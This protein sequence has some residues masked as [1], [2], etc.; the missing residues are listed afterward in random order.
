MSMRF[1]KGLQTLLK[2]L[3]SCGLLYLLYR[4]TPVDSIRELLGSL[5][6]RYLFPIAVMLVFNTVISAVKWQ[7]FLRA[8]G[9]G[10]P[11]RPLVA[12]YLIGSFY[13]MFL[14]SNIG[15]DSYR[16]YDIARKSKETA[17]TAVS[18]L[19]DR[20]SG[21][22]AMLSVGLASACAIG[23]QYDNSS[24][25]VIPLTVF[26][27]MVVSLYLLFKQ[28]PV[29]YLLSVTRLERIGLLKKIVD[30]LLLSVARY[31][32]NR[33]LLVKVMLFSYLFQCSVFFIVFLLSRAIH[34]Q[35]PFIYFCAFVPLISLME[36]LPISING[37]G[38]R[39]AGY[40]F[41]FGSVGMSDIE[42][43]SL[44]LLFLAMSICYSM[45][46]GVVYLFRVLT[47]GQAH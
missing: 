46:G 47:D 32:A 44:A 36:V 23:S 17:R 45:C 24:L 20:V 40:V 25:I 16:I 21:F 3:V 28:Q 31:G 13:N 9:I 42:T 35:L 7:Q 37:I 34:S 26:S 6:V 39:D 22:L 12:S 38:L 18:V 15:G 29:R 2:L 33:R 11:L 10:V 5:D 8:D 43:R 41:F 1:K 4:K 14:P 30:K 19:A 27:A